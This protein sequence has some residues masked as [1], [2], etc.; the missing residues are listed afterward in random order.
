MAATRRAPMKTEDDAPR[1]SIL[2]SAT[3]LCVHAYQT[4]SNTC[5]FQE[6]N[7][8]HVQARGGGG[9]LGPRHHLPQQ[10]KIKITASIFFSARPTG[11]I[12]SLS[13]YLFLSLSFQRIQSWADDR[14]HHGGDG[15]MI[16]ARPCATEK[17]GG[18]VIHRQPIFINHTTGALDITIWLDGQ[19]NYIDIPSQSSS[20]LHLAPSTSAPPDVH[21][22]S[23][24]SSASHPASASTTPTRR[25]ST[26]SARH[27]NLHQ[28]F[29]WRGRRQH[30]RHRT[31]T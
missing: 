17:D 19:A 22:M 26:T 25:H 20:T 7:C 11:T 1:L 15:W 21:M 4:R 9:H 8:G 10:G 29:I 2:A 30:R 12:F 28:L 24:S 5:I 13:P 16:R 23:P 27:C 14:T 3:D 6:N 18:G 31:S